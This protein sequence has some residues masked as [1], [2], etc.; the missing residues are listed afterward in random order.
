MFGRPGWRRAQWRRMGIGD[1][2]QLADLS[3]S[4]ADWL[5]YRAQLLI[6]VGSDY[7]N[8][9]FLLDDLN[10]AATANIPDGWVEQLIGSGA[11]AL[12]IQTEGGGVSQLSTGTTAAS[13]ANHT[14]KSPIHRAVGTVPFYQAVRLKIT[15]AVT[16][17]STIYAGLLDVA[18]TK[19]IAAG[20]FGALNP[21]NFVVQYDG[22]GTG[23]VINTGVAVDNAWHVFETWGIGDGK[24]HAA[25]DFGADVGGVTMASAPA[26]SCHIARV[27]TNGTDAVART[28]LFDYV[29]AFYRRT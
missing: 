14:T 11:S 24:L 28:A 5:P 2:D 1:I 10:Q 7:R 21:T 18:A 12:N 23:S 25:V 15:T 13:N 6:G 4:L 27:V 16:A 8:N 26:G 9:G 22:I 17:Q 20:F 29:A 19:T 3:L